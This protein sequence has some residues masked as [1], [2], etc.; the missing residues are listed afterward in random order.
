LSIRLLLSWGRKEKEKSRKEHEFGQRKN[1]RNS[2]E[3]SED[4]GAA[5]VPAPSTSKAPISRVHDP[6][7]IRKEKG[8]IGVDFDLKRLKRKAVE[9]RRR[10]FRSE[11]K[12]IKRNQTQRVSK[13]Q[14][15][16]EKKEGKKPK[17]KQSKRKRR[18]LRLEL[19][20]VQLAHVLHCKGAR[21]ERGYWRPQAAVSK[22]TE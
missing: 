22:L 12:R 18:K 10:K 17:I 21:G 5:S 9:R 13:Q 19:P 7:E 20:G 6:R 11:E 1:Q 15:Q 8:R 2:K 14:K 4:L 16:G 3:E